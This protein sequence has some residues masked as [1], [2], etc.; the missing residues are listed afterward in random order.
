MKNIFK[1]GEFIFYYT[2]LELSYIKKSIELIDNNLSSGMVELEKEFDQELMDK[3]K[4]GDFGLT[5]QEYKQRFTSEWN[6]TESI[7]SSINEAI[8]VKIYTI[9][10]KA[11]IRF[12][13][14]MQDYYDCKIPPDFN[15][16]GNYSN[17]LSAIEYIKLLSGFDISKIVYWKHIVSLRNIRNRLS[18][19]N[20]ILSMDLKDVKK[21]NT[22]FYTLYNEDKISLLEDIESE[23]GKQLVRISSNIKILYTIRKIIVKT[24]LVININYFYMRVRDNRE[25]LNPYLYGENNND[26]YQKILQTIK[27]KLDIR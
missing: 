25:N 18:H 4:E 2:N 5:F 27:E 10:E 8:L 17:I 23:E 24:I 21:I 7:A 20:T 22:L 14:E 16:R 3:Y 1:T 26:E 9:F 15:V 13:Y 11:I 12:S 6:K 19:G